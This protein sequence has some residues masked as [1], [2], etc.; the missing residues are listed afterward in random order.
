[1]RRYIMKTVHN[2][3]FGIPDVGRGSGK[4][5]LMTRFK[6]VFC[7]VLMVLAFGNQKILGQGAGISEVAP[8]SPHASSI[9]ELQSVTKGFLAPRMTTGE[10]TLI[11]AP[12]DGLLVYDTTTESF[13][14][15]DAGSLSWKDF[16]GGGEAWGTMNQ[17]LGM[18]ADGTAHEYKTLVETPNQVL[19]AHAPGSITLST[20]QNI[21]AGATPTF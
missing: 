20:P 21:H 18:N 3:S 5:T 14:Y 9:L 13:W 7:A 16:I 8:I 10:R 2:K 11:A 15:Y 4:R 19:V 1:M 17:I 6:I 12:A